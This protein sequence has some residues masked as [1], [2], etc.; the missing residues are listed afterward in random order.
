MDILQPI[1]LK[2]IKFCQKNRPSEIWKGK[3]TPAKGIYAT[4]VKNDSVMALKFKDKKEVCILVTCI[5]DSE[6]EKIWY[7]AKYTNSYR[8]LLQMDA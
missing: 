3:L 6:L 1:S 5:G 7:C 8:L 4:L 2:Y